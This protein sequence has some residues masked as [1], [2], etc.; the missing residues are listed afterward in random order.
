M[1][2]YKFSSFETGIFAVLA[3][4]AFMAFSSPAMA[5]TC[6]EVCKD[7]QHWYCG[8]YCA[9]FNIH[10]GGYLGQ[11]DGWC[12]ES[13]GLDTCCCWND[14]NSYMIPMAPPPMDGFCSEDAYCGILNGERGLFYGDAFKWNGNCYLSKFRYCDCKDSKCVNP[15]GETFQ[16]L[17]FSF[18]WIL[19]GYIL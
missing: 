12:L 19:S 15:F 10:M 11:A 7:Y 13:R 18:Y 2:R 5:E 8:D 14:D 1:G 4:F 17:T 6:Q 9:P 16:E 3:L